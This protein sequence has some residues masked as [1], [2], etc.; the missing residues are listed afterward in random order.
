MR[1]YDEKQI[2]QAIDQI[3]SG[4]SAADWIANPTNI[5]LTNDAG[6]VAL[7]EY[8]FPTSKIYTGHYCFVSRGKNAVLAAKKLLDEIFNSCYN[9]RIMMG[10]VPDHRREVKWLSRQLGFKSQGTE[11]LHDKLYEIFILT[12]EQHNNG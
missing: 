12:K 3:K 5:A 9:V 1:T 11:E 7:F 6:D 10:F 2:Q 8:G 4:V